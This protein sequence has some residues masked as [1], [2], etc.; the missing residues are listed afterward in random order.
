M[1]TLVAVADSLVRLHPVSF[2]RPVSR[3][4]LDPPPLF[5][6]CVKR[7]AVPVSRFWASMLAVG[8]GFLSA[9]V[10][11][12]RGEVCPAVSSRMLEALL[13]PAGGLRCLRCFHDV[14]HPVT[15]HE[16]TVVFSHIRSVCHHDR[17][18]QP[19]RLDKRLESPMPGGVP[20]ECSF[21]GTR[22]LVFRVKQ[23]GEKLSQFCAPGC[24]P[25]P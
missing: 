12:W 9:W 1:E 18:W 7:R 14:T 20:A 5:L 10:C 17:V 21:H 2:P 8:L 25:S 13:Q 22:G 3:L 23:P 16:E 6:P 24:V 4:L 11:G 19:I 15:G